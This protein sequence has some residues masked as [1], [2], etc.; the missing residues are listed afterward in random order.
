MINNLQRALHISRSEAKRSR[1]P[2]TNPSHYD[3][4]NLARM[5]SSGHRTSSMFHYGAVTTHG[6]DVSYKHIISE[7][8]LK[9]IARL[10]L[11]ETA[12]LEATFHG[13]FQG[14]T[15]PLKIAAK[16]NCW[17][18]INRSRTAESSIP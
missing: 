5:G 14:L 12:V 10:G 4:V 16:L 8:C 3:S 2:R 15:T 13:T 11:N 6:A 9:Q 18:V 17:K 7:V 1:L